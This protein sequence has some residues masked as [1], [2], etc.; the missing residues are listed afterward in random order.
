[1]KQTNLRRLTTMAMLTAISMIVFLIEAQIPLPFTVPGIKL[2]V[3]NVITLFALWT[4]GKKEAGAILLIRV[5]LGNLIVGNVMGMAFSLAGGGLCWVVMCLMKPIT[6]RNHI[7]VMSIFGAI[8]HNVGQLLVAVAVT[9]TLSIA[10]YAPVLFLAAL[11][12]GFFTGQC[13]QAVLN[14]MD[15]LRARPGRAPSPTE[16]PAPDKEEK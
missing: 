5:V 14:H 4:L 6:Q 2:G 15:K 16:V 9:D 11:V 3:A 7:W 8:A 1:M 10:W 12:T 13:A